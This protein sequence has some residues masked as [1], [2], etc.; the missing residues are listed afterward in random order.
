MPR[1]RVCSGGRAEGRGG[2]RVISNVPGPWAPFPSGGVSQGPG[3]SRCHQR[4][5]GPPVGRAPGFAGTVASAKVLGGDERERSLQT[6]SGCQHS[7]WGDEEEVA[8]EGA[9]GQ[10][11]RERGGLSPRDDGVCLPGPNSARRALP[12][13]WCKPPLTALVVRSS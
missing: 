3:T 12:S 1:C 13:V 8:E 5:Q 4:L 10:E 6:Q 2:Y 7:C 9:G 11:N